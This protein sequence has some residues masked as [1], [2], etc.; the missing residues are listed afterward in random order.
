M[1][2]LRKLVDFVY[3][4]KWEDIPENVKNAT[5]NV[6]FDTVGVCLCVIKK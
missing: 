1:T 5:R 3:K 6:V 4:L 2:E